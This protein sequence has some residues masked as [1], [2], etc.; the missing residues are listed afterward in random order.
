[1]PPDGLIFRPAIGSSLTVGYFVLAASLQPAW[2]QQLFD[3]SK[4][5]IR[6]LLFKWN[7]S[8]FKSQLNL[9]ICS[10]NVATCWESKGAYLVEA[11]LMALLVS[12][13]SKMISLHTWQPC[14][15]YLKLSQFWKLH[16]LHQCML[17]RKLPRVSQQK[18]FDQIMISF[19][20][21]LQG[22]VRWQSVV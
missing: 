18:I 14:R 20:G 13:S 8:C 16:S 6:R 3:L 1:M 21:L 19:Q 11:I 5:L 2:R 12:F 10:S 15:C 9:I 4:G 22:Q 7:M 17:C